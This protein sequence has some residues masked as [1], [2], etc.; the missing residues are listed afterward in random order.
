MPH[1]RGFLQAMTG[2]A[3]G[4]VAASCCL[5][6]AG[7]QPAAGKARRTVTVGGRRVKTVDIHSHCAVPEALALMRLPAGSS[8]R[9]D[10]PQLVIGPDRL[11]VM[12]EQGIDVEALSINP[13]WYAAERDLAR[14][15]I[16]LQNQKLSALCAAYPDRFVA[17]ASVALQHPDLAAQ[18]LEDGKKLGLR[19]AAIG[20]NVN[21][22]ELSS[23]RFDPFWAKAEEL[24]APIFIHP[25]GIPELQKRFQ[26]NGYLSNVIGNPLETTIALSHLIFDGTLDR[27][28][29]LKICA[30]HGG[31]YLPSYSARS[32]HGCATSP[33][34]CAPTPLKKHPSEYLRQLYFDSLVFTPEALRHLVAECGASQ[35]VMGTDWPFPWTTTAVDHILNTPG[36]SADERRGMLGG[37]A[38]K[39]LGINPNQS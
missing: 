27:F 30:A 20:G 14:Q 26:G 4:I 25:Q 7:A 33:P 3:A 2:A 6:E 38:S 28:P 17:F 39:L 11:H 23:R 29:G 13:F 37:T 32:D 34:D 18:Q 15:I 35:I 9:W 1:R 24:G 19:G 22:E 5:V 36:L 12:D 21:G 31:G 8:A 10:S 16:Q